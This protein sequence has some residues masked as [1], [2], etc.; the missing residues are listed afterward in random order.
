MIGWVSNSVLVMRSL[1]QGLAVLLV[2]VAGA[3]YGQNSSDY[4]VVDGVTIYYAVLPAEM[5][6]TFSPG[7]EEARM[8]GGVPGGRHVHHVQ[9]ALFDAQSNARITDARVAATI[10]EVGLGGVTKDLEPFVVGDALTYGGFFEFRKRDLYQIGV[11]VTL[12]DTGQEISKTFKYS[13]K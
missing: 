11:Q 5:L 7:S 12:A 1:R 8:H 10:A 13:H 3:A 2:V 9:V 6:Q 4:A